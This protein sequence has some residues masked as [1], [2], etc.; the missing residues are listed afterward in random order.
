M[1]QYKDSTNTVISTLNRKLGHQKRNALSYGQ[2]AMR[3]MNGY[4]SNSIIY[5]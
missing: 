3:W 1:V 4:A 2:E 5:E